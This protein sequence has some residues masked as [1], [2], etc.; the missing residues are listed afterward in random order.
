MGIT[1][2]VEV[3]INGRWVCDNTLSKVRSG[4]GWEAVYWPRCLLLDGQRFFDLECRGLP[5]DISET[6]R[7]MAGAYRG[8]GSKHSWL[9][10][11]EAASLCL[12]MDK[13]PIARAA[14]TVDPCDYY[15][16]EKSDDAANYRLVYWF[17][18]DSPN[19]RDK[20]K[21]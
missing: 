18:D 13:D 21:E 15:F 8:G 14:A 17:Y 4:P 20:Q 16:Y 7:H 3:R 6:G 2:I 5:N 1:G 19:S 10:L 12:E 11:L 9:P